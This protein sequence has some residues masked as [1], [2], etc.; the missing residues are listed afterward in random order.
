MSKDFEPLSTS[1]NTVI[2]DTDIGP[3]CDDAGAIAVLCGMKKKYGFEVA[4]IVNCTSN[5]F[6]DA[7]IREIAA[8]C[9]LPGVA[10]GHNVDTDF[11]TDGT[12]YNKYI[13]ENMS[14]DFVNGT[15]GARDSDEIYREALESAPDGGV[16]VISIG[17][18]TTLAR[19]LRKYSELFER[20]VSCLV[21][22]ACATPQGREYNVFCDVEAARTVLESFPAPIILSGY[23]IGAHMLTGYPDEPVELMGVNPLYTA[24]H[25][26]TDGEDVRASYDLTAVQFAAEGGNGF[27][28]LS[29]PCRV[30]VDADGTNHVTL[31]P[32]G[33]CRY[34][35]KQK[36]D[37]EI[38][39]Y[40][41][42]FLQ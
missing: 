18:F 29:E 6:G 33:N 41:N 39:K 17:M 12:K 16:T 8:F 24:Y 30:T 21:S 14:P 28:S 25:L 19:A 38:A 20:K 2:L 3:D 26:Y 9:G 5:R 4:S 32:D 10:I 40:L 35:I 42:T 7:A 36:P 27:Y 37:E 15:L 22:M 1:G 23:D 31:T 13:A 34:M 11:I